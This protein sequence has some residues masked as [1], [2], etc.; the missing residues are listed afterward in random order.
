MFLWILI[1]QTIQTRLEH[2]DKQSNNWFTIQLPI[3]ILRLNQSQLIYFNHS[4]SGFYSNLILKDQYL[5]LTGTDFVFKLN[6]NQIN[7]QDI[8]Y[9]ERSLKPTNK[10]NISHFKNHNFIKF[11][12]PRDLTNDLIVCG[13]NL[14]KP[15]IYDLKES[16]LTNQLEY[17]GDYLCAGV[18]DLKSLNLIDLRGVSKYGVMYSGIWITEL[19]SQA[20]GIFSR[21][22]LFRKEIEINRHFLRSL[23]SPYWLWEPDFIQIMQDEYTLLLACIQIM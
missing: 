1:F 14:G 2:I 5:Y 22:G 3:N 18:D 23:F 12:S 9:K 17:N 20:Y 4:Q 10:N 13:T 21:Y 6:S 16:D 19:S 11:L 15:H 8:D 7:K